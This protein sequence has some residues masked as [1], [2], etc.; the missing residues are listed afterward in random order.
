MSV[1]PSRPMRVVVTSIIVCVVVVSNTLAMLLASRKVSSYL[2]W[3]KNLW[4]PTFLAPQS[5]VEQPQEQQ[6]QLQYRDPP[7]FIP[8]RQ[9]KHLDIFAAAWWM[10]RE[11]F[12]TV[13]LEKIGS[14][15][16]DAFIPILHAG[17]GLKDARLTTDWL[18]FSLEHLSKWQKMLGNNP[19][20]NELAERVCREYVLQRHNHHQTVGEGSSY[21]HISDSWMNTTLAVIPYGVSDDT[22][23]STQ[24]IWKWYLKATILSLVQHSVKRIVVVEYYDTGTKLVAEAFQELLQESY[25]TGNYGDDAF[26]AESLHLQNFRIVSTELAY[27]R[28]SHVNTTFIAFNVPYGALVGL[29]EAF[30]GQVKGPPGKN[31]GS[32]LGAHRTRTNE[33]FSYIYMTEADQILHARLSRT[34]WDQLDDNRVVIPHRLQPIP[35]QD[36]INATRVALQLTNTAVKALPD[37]HAPPIT[38]FH[39]TSSDACCDAPDKPRGPKMCGAFW[40]MCGYGG[41]SGERGNFSH[42]NTFEFMRLKRHGTGIV[43]L[44]GNEHGRQ[45]RVKVGGR[46]TCDDSRSGNAT[47]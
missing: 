37:S 17:Q 44:A 46:G 11:R 21:Y 40:W 33:E 42:F 30:T 16:G 22:P 4:A 23:E 24:R 10:R 20:G 6:Q 28:T 34:F 9:L 38:L 12:Q 3:E 5:H 39:S 27:V 31:Q 45:C 36:D 14:V 26:A 29:Q 15:E 18:D 25:Q 1:P 19:I 32:F 41:G 2:A 35:H 8:S 43:T 13:P 7:T 47:K